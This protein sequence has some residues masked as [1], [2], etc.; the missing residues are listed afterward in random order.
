MLFSSSIYSFRAY[1]FFQYWQGHTLKRQSFCIVHPSSRVS[2]TPATWNS[3]KKILQNLYNCVSQTAVCEHIQRFVNFLWWFLNFMFSFQ[4]WLQIL[5]KAFYN[6]KLPQDVKDCFQ[7]SD[8]KKYYFNCQERMRK[9]QWQ[10]SNIN[11]F[12]PRW[13]S[14]EATISKQTKILLFKQR[15]EIRKFSHHMNYG[16]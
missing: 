8:A 13:E 4:G 3:G 10:N 6:R 11:T 14:S 1:C 2:L 16:R 12:M 9:G 15:K 5:V 7:S